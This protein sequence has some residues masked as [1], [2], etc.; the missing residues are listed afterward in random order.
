[1]LQVPMCRPV[2]LVMRCILDV[3]LSGWYR[4]DSALTTYRVGFCL[5]VIFVEL[6]GNVTIMLLSYILHHFQAAC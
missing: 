4:G 6:Y 5:I 2:G 1:M 3:T